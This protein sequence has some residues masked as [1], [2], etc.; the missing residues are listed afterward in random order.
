MDIA[1]LL[2]ETTRIEF[3][4][5]AHKF[6]LPKSVYEQE[7]VCGNVTG[8]DDVHEYTIDAEIDP[9]VFID[10]LTQY[11]VCDK[12][13]VGK[14]YE[15]N[16]YEFQKI[17]PATGM[18]IDK[19]MNSRV[20][21]LKW[22][23]FEYGH[24]IDKKHVFDHDDLLSLVNILCD[25]KYMGEFFDDADIAV[26]KILMTNFP[27][28]W[29]RLMRVCNLHDGHGL[30]KFT[31]D[32]DAENGQSD[33]CIALMREYLLKEDMLIL[34]FVAACLDHFGVA[35]E[36]IVP[37]V[38]PTEYAE[39][40][41]KIDADKKRRQERISAHYIKYRGYDPI[42]KQHISDCDSDDEITDN[43]TE[44]EIA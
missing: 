15:H 28:T 12:L 42:K 29:E 43:E 6:S 2:I 36:H 44:A 24:K 26:K 17:S 10:E 5:N 13:A 25:E 41:K 23:C 19:Y 18:F 32:D 21:L 11:I 8:F 3:T 38:D 9:D 30:I 16:M 27:T 20:N 4:V 39:H 14:F 22:I 7:F 33:L 35:L 34:R 31:I 40:Y 1:K 37:N